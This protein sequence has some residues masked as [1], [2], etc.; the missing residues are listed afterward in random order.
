MRRHFMRRREP[1]MRRQ[2][3]IL[4]RK[5]ILCG[6]ILYLFAATNFIVPRKYRAV[7]FGGKKIIKK[8]K[9]L[10]AATSDAAKNRG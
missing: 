1:F 3:F 5:V 7:F 6:V 2:K 9:T 10:L 4:P 8:F